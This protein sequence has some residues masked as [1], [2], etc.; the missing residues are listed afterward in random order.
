MNYLPVV[1]VPVDFPLP[2]PEVMDPP[3]V[4]AP[5]LEAVAPLDVPPEAEPE[6]P[7]AEPEVPE[8]E[9]EVPEELESSPVMGAGTSWTLP[10]ILG[11]KTI[12][13]REHS[14]M[15]PSGRLRRTSTVTLA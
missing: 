10:T 3:D 15:L 1:L 12:C 11:S 2:P 14:I 7:E 5:L 13:D 6:V 9:P 4:F 8:A